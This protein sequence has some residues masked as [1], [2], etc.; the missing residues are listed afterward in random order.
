MRRCIRPIQPRPSPT[1]LTLVAST[2]RADP[3]GG[4]ISSVVEAVVAYLGEGDLTFD[5]HP[6]SDADA[7][8]AGEDLDA[9]AAQ[10]FPVVVPE[11]IH[12]E[13]GHVAEA[14]RLRRRGYAAHHD[15]LPRLHCGQLRERILGRGVK[16][17]D[18]DARRRE[19]GT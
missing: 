4:Q 11:V 16:Q 8:V 14:T 9:P 5:H 13:I 10:N 6:V 12:P 2:R 19:Q 7:Q 1:G 17:C 3:L 18:R 15:D